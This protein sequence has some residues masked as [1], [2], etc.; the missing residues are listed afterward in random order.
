MVTLM[1]LIRAPKAETWLRAYARRLTATDTVI[2]IVAVFSAQLLRFGLGS[3][4]LLLADSSVAA[5]DVTYTVVSVL[6]VIGWLIALTVHSSR[7]HT[8]IGNGTSEYIRVADASLRY[9]G[10][11]AIIA[12][13]FKIQLARGYLLLALPIGVA[14][15]LLSRWMWRNWLAARRTEGGFVRRAVVIGAHDAAEHVAE[16]IVRETG[17]GIMLIGAVTDGVGDEE[18]VPGVSRIGGFDDITAQLDAVGADTVVYAGS[19]AISPAQLREL[20]WD[21]DARQVDLIVAPKLT[22]IAGPRIHARPVAGLPL[23]HVEYP[24][25]TGMRYATKRAF[26]IL[27]SAALLTLLSPILLLIAVLVRRDG[28]PALFM[29]RRVGLDGKEF[30]MI[31]FRSM[32]ADAEDRLASLLDQNEGN[33]VLFKMKDDPRITRI[34]KTLRR[35]SLDELPQLWNVL[36]GDMSLVGPRPPLAKEVSRYGEWMQRRFLVKPGITGLWQ[37][38]G[39]SDL[40]WEESVRLDLYYVENWSLT[41]DFLLLWRTARAVAKADGAY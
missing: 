25:F 16:Q 35:Y 10:V 24:S 33:D 5:N 29:Q 34:G 26:D 12:F 1:S 17:S 21:L 8:I 13:L 15:L 39:R 11:V 28:H 18:L 19:D 32:T 6:V 37:V 4:D 27:G 7:D 20:G 31:K 14:L 38:S 41:T 23:I 3:S 22:D 40:S 36:R 9:F 30:A 2:V